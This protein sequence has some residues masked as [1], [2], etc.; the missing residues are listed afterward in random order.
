MG[1][2]NNKY[3]KEFKL[4]VV[5]KYL[6]G[7]YSIQ[8]LADEFGVSSK[9]QIY[10]WVKKYEKDGED[11]FIFETRGNPKAKKMIDRSFIFDNLESELQFLRMENE[12]LKKYT[13][14]L[15]KRLQEVVVENR[16]KEDS[17]IF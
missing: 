2:I 11:A 13:D 1:R 4:K 17:D 16:Q 12:Y 9:T 5:K 8:D 10:N 3:S 15:K 6:E 14:L 7:N